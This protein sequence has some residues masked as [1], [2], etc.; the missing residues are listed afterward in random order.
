MHPK[1]HYNGIQKKKKKKI[2]IIEP[3]ASPFSGGKSN[4]ALSCG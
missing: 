3:S 4:H 1:A 2:V